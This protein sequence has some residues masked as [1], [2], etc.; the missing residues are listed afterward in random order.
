MLEANNI[1]TKEHSR[2]PVSDRLVKTISAAKVCNVL[3]SLFCLSGLFLGLFFPYSALCNAVAGREIILGNTLFGLILER[4]QGSLTAP[5]AQLMPVLLYHL[6]VA[7]ATTIALSL[8]ITVLSLLFP[9]AAPKLLYWNVFFVLLG[10]TLAAFL[11]FVNGTDFTSALAPDI[12]IPIALAVLVYAI[13]LMTQRRNASGVLLFLL[14]FGALFSVAVPRSPLKE[15][16]FDAFR[17]PLPLETTLCLFLLAGFASL[18]AFWA[19]TRIGS[20]RGY[21]FE[22]ILFSLQCLSLAAYVAMTAITAQSFG[23]ITAEPYVF[24]ALSLFP[25]VSLI[26]SVVLFCRER[27][28]KK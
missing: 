10:N 14:S 21:L 13:Y 17:Q 11:V 19:L 28:K 23:F 27:A 15:A 5:L 6:P 3:V 22:V 20:R 26:V 16:L 7:A 8:L 24:A 2:R 9:K 4:L 18:N 1:R 25:I 12:L